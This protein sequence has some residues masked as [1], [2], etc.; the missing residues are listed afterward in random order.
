MSRL[1]AHWHCQHG[2]SEF[3][4]GF[5]GVDPLEPL[6]LLIRHFRA[7]LVV[8][9]GAFRRLTDSGYLFRRRLLV[10]SNRIRYNHSNFSS[11]L[12]SMS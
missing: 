10:F 2:L 4:H 11:P 8:N 9:N 5:G 12:K 3:A 6:Q 7:V 1:A